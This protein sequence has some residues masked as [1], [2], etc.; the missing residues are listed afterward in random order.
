MSNVNSLKGKLHSK[1]FFSSQISIRS[2][3]TIFFFLNE[4]FWENWILKYWNVSFCLGLT[5]SPLE[6][7]TVWELGV[8][9][10]HKEQI[11]WVLFPHGL[12]KNID[13]TNAVKTVPHTGCKGQRKHRNPSL[14]FMRHFIRSHKTDHWKLPKNPKCLSSVCSNPAL[15]IFWRD[16]LKME[17]KLK[18]SLKKNSVK[19]TLSVEKYSDTKFLKM[20]IIR[21]YS[22]SYYVNWTL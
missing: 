16:S 13:T 2:Q 18:Y 15:V 1:V 20:F 10:F 22:H 19:S 6:H 7:I 11:F 17:E 4:L 5:V 9:F 12:N 8:I 3:S 21:K 14:P